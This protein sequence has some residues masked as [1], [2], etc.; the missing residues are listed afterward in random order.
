[1]YTLNRLLSSTNE[2]KNPYEILVL[3]YFTSRHVVFFEDL[4]PMRPTPES[5]MKFFKD[6]ESLNNVTVHLRVKMT[7]MKLEIQLR[8][9]EYI[10][11]IEENEDILIRLLK[12]NSRGGH[13]HGAT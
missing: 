12:L 13:L 6:E 5:D 10:D 9:V 3:D 1:V 8:G 2:K 7:E 4:I 11:E